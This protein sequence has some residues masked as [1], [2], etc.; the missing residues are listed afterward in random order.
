M[1]SLMSVMLMMLLM[2]L[3]SYRG[4]LFRNDFSLGLYL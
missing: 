4:L 3:M 2:F 1:M